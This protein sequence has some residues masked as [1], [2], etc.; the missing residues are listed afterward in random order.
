MLLCKG[1]QI[2]NKQIDSIAQIQKKEHN[3]SYYALVMQETNVEEVEDNTFAG[4]EFEK[5][6]IE[7]NP[8]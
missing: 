2:G 8:N 7:D 6:F 5:I 1:K 3:F 4:F